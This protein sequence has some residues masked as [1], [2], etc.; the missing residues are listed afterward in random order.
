M[1]KSLFLVFALLFSHHAS[2]SDA[3]DIVQSI[4]SQARSEMNLRLPE[5]EVIRW[6]DMP[7]DLLPDAL[8][9]RGGRVYYHGVLIKGGARYLQGVIRASDAKVA[10]G[11]MARQIVHIGVLGSVSILFSALTVAVG[12]GIVDIA[13][14]AVVATV[15]AATSPSNRKVAKAYS[16]WAQANPDQL[17]RTL[18]L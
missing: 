13:I 5:G 7:R 1:W 14:Y 3:V 9:V 6:K 4:E 10:K 18:K 8:E 15:I 16:E 2:A 12:V 17:E 11:L